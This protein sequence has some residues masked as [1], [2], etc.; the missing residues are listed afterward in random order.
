LRANPFWCRRSHSQFQVTNNATKS[1]FSSPPAAFHTIV[2]YHCYLT[3]SHFAL[4]T[5]SGRV[6]SP[7]V[8]QPPGTSVLLFLS[9][10]RT[11]WVF[12]GR[13][14]HIQSTWAD[15]FLIYSSRLYRTLVDL[16]VNTKRNLTRQ[17]ITN[18]TSLAHK[19]KANHSNPLPPKQIYHGSYQPGRLGRSGP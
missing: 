11:D 14:V 13:R 16:S 4:A 18:N 3:L 8:S 7:D 15:D 12:G 6:L 10:R 2:Q 1:R 19:N 9:N 5:K 17:S